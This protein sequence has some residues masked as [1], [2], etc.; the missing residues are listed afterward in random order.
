MDLRSTENIVIETNADNTETSL[1]IVTV[2][3]RDGGVYSVVTEN[4]HGETT[5]NG[6]LLLRSEWDGVER[7]DGMVM[8]EGER[9]GRGDCTEEGQQ[10]DILVVNQQK[11]VM[12]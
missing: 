5:S 2:G 10:C 6:V 8:R 4:P 9:K 3:M 11:R 12:R 1:T 7:W